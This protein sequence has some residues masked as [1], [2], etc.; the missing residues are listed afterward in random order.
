ML[1]T[2]FEIFALRDPEGRC[3]EIWLATSDS[4]DPSLQHF[5][6]YSAARLR[7]KR[8]PLD[9]APPR[10]AIDATFVGRLQ[11]THSSGF[12]VDGRNRVSGIRG[13]FGHLGQY[14]TRIL[15]HSVAGLHARDLLGSVYKTSEYEQYPPDENCKPDQRR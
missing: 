6:N 13:H 5:S 4:T 10:Y 2:G 15:L 9:Y 7:S 12:M 14:K 11:Y 1:A 3:D 8:H